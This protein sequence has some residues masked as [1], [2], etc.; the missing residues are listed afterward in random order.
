MEKSIDA[1]RTISEVAEH[2]DT[3]AHVL[4]FWE[5]RF[6]QIKPVKRAGG[7]RYYRHADVALLSG[8][9]HLL[10]NEGMTIR[11]VQ[12]ML[13][14][15]GVR[16]ISSLVGDAVDADFDAV[17]ALAEGTK[18]DLSPPPPPAEVV[19]LQVWKSMVPD[20]PAVALT[21]TEMPAAKTPASAQ[22]SLPFDL[23]TAQTKPAPLSLTPVEPHWPVAEVARYEAQVTVTA[24]AI[25]SP[26]PEPDTSPSPLPPLAAT[27]ELPLAKTVSAG[28]E[29][30]PDAD[31]P[32]PVE[33]AAFK[34]T[35][36]SPTVGQPAPPPAP[37]TTPWLPSRLRALPH[38]A[39]GPHIAEL[40]PLYDRL[41]ALRDRMVK[42]TNRNRI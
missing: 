9:R 4:R 34:A 5:S 24:S 7:R 16:H 8:I 3:P 39:V 27:P 21:E 17:V 41:T 31:A 18:F 1:F 38:G 11:G 14:E 25:D 35:D 40:R 36:D 33:T 15:Q 26:S 20:A 30:R 37:D 32:Q 23:T 29:T 42:A 19:D 12:K 2:L 10:H 22:F 13:R 6:P 28:D